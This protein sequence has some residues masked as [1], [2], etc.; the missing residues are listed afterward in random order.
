MMYEHD[1]GLNKNDPGNLLRD[2]L[3]K[4]TVTDTGSCPKV[5]DELLYTATERNILPFKITVDDAYT[6]ARLVLLA[7]TMPICPN[8]LRM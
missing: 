7:Q 4:T 2:L 5:L 1:E 8:K 6:I 3:R